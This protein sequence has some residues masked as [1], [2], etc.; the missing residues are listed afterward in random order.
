M[1]TLHL[2]ALALT[3]LLSSLPASANA[4]DVLAYHNSADR[5]G[6]YV[7]P[8]LTPAT[9]AAIRADAG[10]HGT[11]PG[12]VYAQPLFWHPHGGRAV[13]IV[14]TESN[15]VV[16]LDAVT[17]AAVWQTNLGPPVPRASLPCGNIDPDGITGTPII[18]A[19]SAVLYVD[20]LTETGSGP[21]QL[22]FALSL[23]SGTVASG[24]PVDVQ[25]EL[26]KRSI[27]F[28]SR[29]QGERGALQ[30]LNDALYVSYGGN[31]GDCGAYR[32]TVVRVQ[33]SPPKLTAVW[34]TRARG[35]GVWAQ[36]GAASDGHSLFVTTGNTFGAQVWSD[37]E[38]V[39]R[40]APDLA[41]SNSSVDYFTPS[42]WKEL[43]DEDADLGGSGAL[44]FDIGKT[45]RILAL[46]KNGMAYLLNRENLGGIG[47]VLTA[48]RL[49]D[50]PI[51]TAPAV[52]QLPDA[53]MVA[54]TNRGGNCSG[55]NVTMLRIGSGSGPI[56]VAW[57]A[58]LRG[59]GA[60]IITTSDGTSGALV[61]AVGAEGDN[62]LHGFDAATGK[63]A[64]SGEFAMAGL[65][66]FQTVLAAEG[67]LY[68]AG[69]A[70]VYAF[71][72]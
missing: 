22:V 58:P 20:A 25:S 32:G 8:G 37:G 30:M 18:D 21:R 61:W 4:D 28:S 53:A 57:C 6:A 70:R 1:A 5:H 49:S 60:P 15:I 14:A 12:H 13:V 68:V 51:I 55:T 56:R 45:K 62:R 59:A 34:Q 3:A 65:H 54:F 33:T 35:G 36:A 9:A 46:G 10:F 67:R 63:E 19:R 24:W 69:D 7:M 27:A 44:P 23:S 43:D 26:A 31:W 38:A 66:H 72:R 50:S 47:G 16:A 11:V 64:Y 48:T 52:L 17:G 29:T 2:R 39:L 40:L 41:H 71:T 42:N